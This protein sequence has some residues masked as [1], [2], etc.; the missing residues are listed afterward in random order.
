MRGELKVGDDVRAL[1]DAERRDSTRLNHTATHL[2]HAALRKVLGTHV[3]QKGSLVAPDR[4]RFDFSHYSAV[5]PE[6]LAEIERLV[7]DEIRATGHE[8]TTRSRRARWRCWR[9]YDGEVRVLQLRR[10]SSAAG[11]TC[12]RRGHGLFKIVSGVAA[13]IRRIEALRGQRLRLRRRHRPGLAR[14]ATSCVVHAMTSRESPPVDRPQPRLEKEVSQLG[15]ARRMQGS[16]GRRR[17]IGGATHRDDRRCDAAAL[18]NAV[19]QLKSG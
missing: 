5:T 2:L 17:R 18:R 4:L 14:V 13:G 7:N 9:E 12:A 19:D 15:Q 11:R 6:Q 8:T 10:P 16:R 1:V 3:T